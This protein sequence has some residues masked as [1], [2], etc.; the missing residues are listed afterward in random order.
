MMRN[1][2][3]CVNTLQPNFVILNINCRTH[4]DIWTTLKNYIFIYVSPTSK[5]TVTV[6]NGVQVV[7]CQPKSKLLRRQKSA[8]EFD[9]RVAGELG[10]EDDSEIPVSLI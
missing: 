5:L 10:G 9:G 7:K 4:M 3:I 2:V 1:F 8:S 6:T